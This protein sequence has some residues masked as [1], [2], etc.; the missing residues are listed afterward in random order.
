MGELSDKLWVIA[1][2]S[3]SFVNGNLPYLEI[4]KTVM[5]MMVLK[6]RFVK[7]MSNKLKIFGSNRKIG[8][9]LLFCGKRSY[10]KRI[11]GY[12]TGQNG[13]GSRHSFAK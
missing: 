6:Y 11:I 3:E 12:D 7:D 8:G 10:L 9:V 1:N 13:G 4:W 5:N 2:N